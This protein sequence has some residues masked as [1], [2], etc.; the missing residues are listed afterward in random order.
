MQQEIKDVWETKLTQ[1]YAHNDKCSCLV[2]S[3]LLLCF[4]VIVFLNLISFVCMFGKVLPHLVQHHFA[5]VALV[6]D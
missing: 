4:V 3:F 5:T 2:H 6:V 1:T